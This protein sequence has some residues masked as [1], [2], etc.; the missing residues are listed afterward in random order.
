MGSSR[1]N[2]QDHGRCVKRLDAILE[3]K[4]IVAAV[5][6][7]AEGELLAAPSKDCSIDTAFIADVSAKVAAL[8]KTLLS[9]A[10]SKSRNI[11]VCDF[12]GSPM[13]VVPA[14]EALVTIIGRPGAN[15]G[16][17]AGVALD[18]AREL[19]AKINLTTGTEAP[20]QEK[21]AKAKP[22]KET[23]EQAKPQKETA[24]QAKPQKETA[25]Q[26]KAQEEALQ[27]EKKD[28]VFDADGFTAR[29]LGALGEQEKRQPQT[30]ET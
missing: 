3:N 18:T 27:E 1:L 21:A 14:K 26:A 16:M 2:E 20:K 24:E 9:Q 7:A 4:E 13:M 10:K 6:A 15:M 25:E 23:A 5:V 22:Q 11:S 12:G 19:A 8:G 28:F 17:I 30:G 29:V